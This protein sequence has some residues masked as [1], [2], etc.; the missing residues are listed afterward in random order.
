ME[1]DRKMIRNAVDHMFIVHTN[2]NLRILLKIKHLWF[3]VNVWTSLNMK[4][5][6]AITTYGITHNWKMIDLNQNTNQLKVCSTYCGSRGKTSKFA[7]LNIKW[8]KVSQM[9]AFLEP[10]KLQKKTCSTACI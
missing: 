3:T 7:L 8:E 9:V 10:L 2:H 4:A 1:F 5:F 6:M